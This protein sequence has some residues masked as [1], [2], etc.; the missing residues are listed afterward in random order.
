[1]LSRKLWTLKNANTLHLIDKYKD[2]PNNSLKSKLKSLKKMNADFI[3]IRYVAKLLRTKQRDNSQLNN[4]P[5]DHD[6]QIQKNFWGYIKTH[7]KK[8]TSLPASFDVY[9]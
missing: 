6:K 9:T 3:E 8:S 1:M 2:C 7:F 5:I 4:L